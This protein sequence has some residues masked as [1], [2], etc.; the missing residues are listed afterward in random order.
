MPGK[1]LSKFDRLKGKLAKKDSVD[2][3]AAL[4]AQIGRK[5]HGRKAF[6]RMAAAGRKASS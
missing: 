6:Q 4:A 5:K 3:P 1:A 2:D